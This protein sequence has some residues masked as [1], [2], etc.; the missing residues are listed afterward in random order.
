MEGWDFVGQVLLLTTA[1][2]SAGVLL[3]SIGINSIIGYLLAG[4]IVGP[5]GF[6][7]VGGHSEQINLIAELG[8]ALLLFGIGLEVS[9]GQIRAFGWRG[10]FVGVIQ[11]CLTL[12]TVMIAGIVF[13]LSWQSATIVGAMV[14]L[15]STA[16]VVRL[17]TDRAELDSAHGRESLAVLLM[18]DVALVPLLILAGM[19]GGSN[20]VSASS[21]I[22]SA[23]IG[24]IVVVGV[25]CILGIY[26]LPRILAASVLRRNRD[27]AIVLAISTCLLSAWGSHALGLSPALG[28]FISGLVLARTS[29]AGQMRADTSALRSLFL[30][31]FFA[32]V[33]MIADLRWLLDW[34]HILL[35]ACLLIG[36]L[37]IKSIATMAAIRLSGGNRRV[38]L[39]TSL[40]LAQFGEFSFVLGS[41]AHAG[42]ILDENIFQGMITASLLSLLGAPFIVARCRPIAR[43]IDQLAIRLKLFRRSRPGDDTDI[44]ARSGH[45]L[46]I[47]FGPAGEEAAFVI[48]QAGLHPLVID[49]NPS[50]IQRAKASDI[51]VMVGDASQREMLEHADVKTAAAA[52]IALPDSEA[53]IST[54]KQVRTLNQHLLIVVRARY[55][56]RIEDLRA[57][58]A[59][60]VIAEEPAVGT[61]LGHRTVSRITGMDPVPL[62]TPE[63]DPVADA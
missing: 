19:L 1:A 9:P 15:S 14:A 23:A 8:V 54:V 40:C 18:Q 61:L 42:G 52:V 45:V 5:S 47:G 10:M 36:G 32:S 13:G 38:S 35:L 7:L 6:N 25:L 12:V 21:Q 50:S 58:G 60:N 53:A 20:E 16:V 63:D 3:E 44:E 56:R 17:L 30:T 33:G 43:K 28:A 22:E 46:I 57:A 34:S 29:F 41:V 11:I 2:V 31:L 26:I 55:Q 27:L 39:E 37:L 62:E 59:D 4:V 48:Q 51:D 24:M 49:L